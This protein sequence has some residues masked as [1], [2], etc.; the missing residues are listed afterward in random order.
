MTS[1]SEQALLADADARALAYLAG[2]NER[3]VYPVKSALD[4]LALFDEA[5]PEAPSAPMATLALLD[6]TG[7]PATVA[8]NGPRYFGFVVGSAHPAAAAAER[9]MLAWDQGAAMAVTSPASAAIEAVAARWVLD[10]L[11]LPADAAVGFGT[12]ATS[13]TLTCLAAA[14]RTLL[15]RAGWDPDEKGLSGA[16]K[17]RVLVSATTHVAVHKSLRILG[18]GREDVTVVPT[19]A[20]GRMDPGQLPSTDA[21]T[22]VCLQA[23][24]VNTGECDDFRA[25][26]PRVRPTGAWVH[27]DGAFGLW[28]RATAGAKHLTDGVEQADSWVTDGHKWLNTPYDSAMAICRRRDDLLGAMTSDAAY[29]AGSE[30]SQK[31]LTLDFSRRPRGIAIWAI[32][33]TLGRSGL[34]AMIARNINQASGAATRLRDNG[35]SVL[36]RVVLNQVLVRCETDAQTLALVAAAQASGKV[37]FGSTV[38][39]GRPAFRLSFSSWRT[40]QADVDALCEVVIGLHR[41]ASSPDG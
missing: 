30:H 25:I 26:I 14:R 9:L 1:E 21:L 36:N 34:D 28:A 5:L 7:S 18:F 2:I 20:T 6:G 40:T 23:G 31:N 13:C 32:L 4:E 16:P 12:S 3:E 38:W 19:D 33:R 8:S 24:E 35:L 10:V 15:R 29:A 11:D 17:V 37:W 41:R 39:Q 22:V 27:V